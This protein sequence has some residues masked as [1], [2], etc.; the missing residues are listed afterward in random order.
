MK[1]HDSNSENHTKV[2]ESITN[3]WG[4]TI[5][6]GCP[7]LELEGRHEKEAVHHLR[8]KGYRGGW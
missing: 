2:W 4:A 3:L 7:A 6:Y 8:S 1:V 5:K